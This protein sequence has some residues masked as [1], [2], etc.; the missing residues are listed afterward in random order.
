MDL[1]HDENSGCYA[2]G[3]VRAKAASELPRAAGRCNQPRRFLFEG[4]TKS[5][6]QRSAFTIH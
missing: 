1:L 5:T 6:H 4:G 2:E 3:A